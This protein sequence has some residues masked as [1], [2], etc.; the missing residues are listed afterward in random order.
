MNLAPSASP[1]PY[2][3]RLPPSAGLRPPGAAHGLAPLGPLG[4]ALLAGASTACLG[5][6]VLT[7]LL[8]GRAAEHGYAEVMLSPQGGPAIEA[9]AG[10]LSL[11]CL[12]VGLA[13]VG[14]PALAGLGVWALT[15]R[16]SR[17]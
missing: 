13:F 5:A 14:L 2:A 11:L 7:G 6:W 3:P 4:R 1:E 12:R 17:V 10:L 8:A 9:V 15:A 16:W